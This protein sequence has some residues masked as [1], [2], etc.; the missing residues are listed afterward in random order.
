MKRREFLTSSMSAALLAALA[1]TFVSSPALAADTIKLGV[2]IPMSGPAGL[3]GPSSK[4]C[5]EM[6]VEEINKSGGILGKQ[7]EVFYADAGGSPSDALK[8]AVRLF[9]G[10]KVD[11][12]IGMHD[13]AVRGALTN[14]FKGKVPYIYTPIY[15]G[16]E[17]AE[18]TY[19]LGETPA[20][21]LAPVIPWLAKNNNASKW[22]LIGN[23]YNWP[24][25]SN[26][27]A[28]D[29]ITASGGEVVGEEYLPFSADNFDSSL[30]KI[31]ASGADAVLIT[32]V[33][34]ASVSFNRAFANFGLDKQAL[35]LGT[36]IEEN[37]LAG[38]GAEN[39]SRLYSSSGY[40][41]NI[42]SP[43]ANS[44]SKRYYDKFGS[45]A[46]ALNALGE[47]CYDGVYLFNALANKAKGV[48][49]E[50]IANASE[51]AS[52]SSP[53]G[54]MTLTQGHVDKDIYLAE[55]VDGAFRVVETFENVPSGSTC[56]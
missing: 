2:M 54:E 30:A 13:S 23:D 43:Q 52:L 10:E 26:A 47:S 1:P 9:K 44:F 55:A 21:Q 5:T 49:A 11:A 16:G 34:G 7:I 37:T 31:K 4:N 50:K 41:Q 35:R 3:F 8:N 51:G 29:Y 56:G 28:K 38:I 22:Y 12:F 20:Q 53:R 32:L 18:G 17:C 39:S 19:V 27:A 6:A 24:R 45:D 14:L 36:L 42:N 40:F 48:S 33:G 46:P 25:D 15:E